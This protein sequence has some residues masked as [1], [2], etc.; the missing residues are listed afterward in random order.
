MSAVLPWLV[1]VAILA[2]LPMLIRWGKRHARGSAGGVAMLI[3]LAFGH[4]FDPAKAAATET[5]AKQRENH[6]EEAEAGGSKP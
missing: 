5:L 4:L 6:R 3:G 1:A 2:S